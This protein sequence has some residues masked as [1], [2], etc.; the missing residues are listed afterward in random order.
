MKK[1]SMKGMDAPS[2]QCSM[3]SL[4]RKCKRRGMRENPVARPLIRNLDPSICSMI[5]GR[6]ISLSRIGQCWILIMRKMGLNA[7]LNQC[8]RLKAISKRELFLQGIIYPKISSNLK[9]LKQPQAPTKPKWTL[10]IC[11][12]SKRISLPNNICKNPPLRIW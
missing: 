8:Y 9:S 3:I 2:S 7:L 5:R 12:P 4:T 10:I 1:W 6:I 11:S